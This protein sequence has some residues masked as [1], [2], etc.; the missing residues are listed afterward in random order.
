MRLKDDLN[1]PDITDSSRNDHL[2]QIQELE[3][4]KMEII[5]NPNTPLN[6]P[7]EKKKR[8]FFNSPRPLLFGN[9]FWQI[10]QEDS[11]DAPVM[12]N[13]E[14]SGFIYGEDINDMKQ[15]RFFEHCIP[16]E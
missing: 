9:Q 14:E 3:S 8:Q 13:N 4:K 2:L 16:P 1:N 10:N 15:A 12:Q 7:I 11:Y 5:Q 6:I